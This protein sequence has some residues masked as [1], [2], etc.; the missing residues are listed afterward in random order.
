M[1]PFLQPLMC[2][3]TKTFLTVYN[4]YYYMNPTC[5]LMADCDWLMAQP[6]ISDA[7]CRGFWD[8]DCAGRPEAEPTSNQTKPNIQLIQNSGLMKT[9]NSS[10]L[11]WTDDYDWRSTFHKAL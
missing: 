4:Y 7:D 8:R 6:D 1:N 2:F 11:T 5:L 10:R 9:T 3:N